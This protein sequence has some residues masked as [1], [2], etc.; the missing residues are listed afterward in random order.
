M[1]K[2]YEKFVK[3]VPAGHEEATKANW[4]YLDNLDLMPYIEKYDDIDDLVDAVEDDYAE[5]LE[6]NEYMKGCVFNLITPDELID[7]IDSK[8]NISYKEEV[9]TV[10]KRGALK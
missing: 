6:E 2:D 8:Y 4:E 5:S 7:F 1:L 3:H 10:Y 9:R